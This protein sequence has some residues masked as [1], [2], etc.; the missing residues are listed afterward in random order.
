M[1]HNV[2]I[3]YA[4]YLLCD[5]QRGRDD[6]RWRIAAI[7]HNCASQYFFVYLEIS[8]DYVSMTI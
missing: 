3:R 7:D 4:G 1:D 8:I 2:N 6:S 5:L